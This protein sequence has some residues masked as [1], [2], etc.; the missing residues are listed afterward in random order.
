MLRLGGVGA[1]R[2][3]GSEIRGKLRGKDS[4]TGGRDEISG[5]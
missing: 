5:V 2:Y 3:G 1:S 4:S